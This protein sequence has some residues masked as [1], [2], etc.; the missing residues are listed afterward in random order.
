[1]VITQK[2]VRF[3]ITN[4]VTGRQYIWEM[5]VQALLVGVKQCCAGKG[6]CPGHKLFPAY[7]FHA[8]Q[9]Y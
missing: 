3:H 1:M 9:L 6:G 2:E 5:R 8:V 7:A 4:G